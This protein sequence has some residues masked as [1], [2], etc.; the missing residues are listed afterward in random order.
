M[1]SKLRVLLFIAGFFLASSQLHADELVSIKAGYQLLTPEGSIAGEI[2]GIGDKVDLQD[3]LGLDDSNDFTGEIALQWG[4]GRL[5]LNYLPINFSG[6]GTL[7]ETLVIDD[8][9]FTVGTKVHSD[10]TLDIYDIGYT[11]YF[12]NVD[13]LPTRVQLGL[14]IAAKIADA[15]FSI[16]E[17]GTNTTVSESALLPIPTL[18]ARA[19]IALAD[20]V[21]VSGRIGYM[22][23]ADAHFMDAE[24]QIEF[25][26]LPL[27]GIYAGYRYLD[28][29]ID[30][31]D[32]YVSTE[33]SGPFAGLMLRF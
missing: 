20:F 12:V 1:G 19:R 30:N 16:K 24:A 13:D 22:G 9:T 27:L 8:Q 18:G 32:F 26:P 6:T 28:L 7:S 15:D 3:D 5:S 25:S 23:Y 14:E 4:N 33:I 10:L 17:N 29:E 11:Y 31:D 2:D 21:G